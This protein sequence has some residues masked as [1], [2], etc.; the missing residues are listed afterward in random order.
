MKKIHKKIISFFLILAISSFFSPAS[1][2]A[3]VNWM[4]SPDFISQ[5]LDQMLKKFGVQEEAIT[6]QSQKANVMS[7][8]MLSPEVFL[9]FSPVNPVPGEKVTAISQPVNFGNQGD[10]MYYT[11]YL[12]HKGDDSQDLDNDGDISIEDYKIEAMRIL[13]SDDF[14]GSEAEVDTDDDGYRAVMG[15][16]DQRN[17]GEE[18][19]CFFHDTESGA[20][21]E[22]PECNQ[23]LFP[24]APGHETGDNDFGL[25]EETFWK[26]DPEDDDTADLGKHDEAT[27]S[28]LGQKSFTWTYQ[29]GD[30][31]GVAIEGIH[32]IPTD[33]DDASYKV[34]WGIT[35]NKCDLN[36]DA[37]DD[38][39]EGGENAPIVDP[40]F[41]P[42]CADGCDFTR[43]VTKSSTSYEQAPS[44]SY[45]IGTTTNT[46][47]TET[48]H[49]S[50]R[51]IYGG[52][53]TEGTGS[54]GAEIGEYSPPENEECYPPEVDDISADW[55]ITDRSCCPP[56]SGD[57]S[58][59]SS[60]TETTASESSME[61]GQTEEEG[62][63]FVMSIDEFNECLLQ[64]FV[65]PAEG[66]GKFKKINVVLTYSPKN[67]INDPTGNTSDKVVVEST[68]D[69]ANDGEFLYYK[70]EVFYGESTAGPWEALPREALDGVGETMGLGVKNLEFNLK[71]PEGI[72]YLKVK[73]TVSESA[74]N[75]E[76]KGHSD[77]IIPVST[78]L[79][80]LRVYEANI[81]DDL[82]LSPGEQK[83]LL[84]GQTINDPVCEVAKNQILAI[85]VNDPNLTD[86]LW[87]IGGESF[88]YKYNE[89]GSATNPAYFP[90]TTEVGENFTVSLSATNRETGQKLN[91]SQTFKV[92]DPKITITSQNE[93]SVVPELLGFYT[94]TD[95]VA[96]PD[97]SE[98]E[99]ET[100]EGSDISLQA[101]FT[102]DTPPDDRIQWF[103][104]G[105][106]YG[107]GDTLTF[108]ATKPIGSSY[109]VTVSSLYTQDNNTAKA[110]S[111]YWNISYDGLYEKT[112]TGELSINTVGTIAE[113]QT[114]KNNI[115]KFLA[116]LTSGFPIYLSFLF[117]IVLTTGLLLFSFRVIFV[118]LPKARKE[119]I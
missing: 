9:T 10:S 116:S 90:V 55:G 95:N 26:T 115:K 52:E 21:Y 16:D 39:A 84:D 92:V 86:F 31:I 34:M 59:V 87:K 49:L 38:P 114:A 56:G 3:E 30:E 27:L 96:W 89:A 72:A 66:G 93:G 110:L 61:P 103:V 46:I 36:D 48:I 47:K 54:F 106:T 85:E 82:A 94:D 80:N 69:N 41:W 35:K 58:V 77:V 119:E 112:I 91:L 14:E 18:P 29:E 53:M 25:D 107:T 4:A 5:S 76:R 42:D 73:L 74:Y 99:F 37:L 98:K 100:L 57:C 97:Y 23:H 117:R 63:L 15:G 12:K 17:V 101:E 108:P 51:I 118:L 65:N 33:Y 20:D 1:A 113:E 13:A 109:S 11:W 2:S 28:G 79:N 105:A 64:N 22:F 24:N 6:E 32:F 75:G 78:N 70:W 44:S 7:K 71:F 43:T 83:C 102:A 111:N 19:H 40:E 50:T 68:I 104:D 45:Q 62:N 60:S 67:P 8:K 88:T 81:S